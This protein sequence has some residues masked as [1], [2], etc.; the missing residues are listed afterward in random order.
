LALKRG[1]SP[2][3]DLCKPASIK[4]YLARKSNLTLFLPI[5][6]NQQKTPFKKFQKMILEICGMTLNLFL[7]QESINYVYHWH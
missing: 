1:Q 7:T 2:F 5:S 6:I 4:A 3:S